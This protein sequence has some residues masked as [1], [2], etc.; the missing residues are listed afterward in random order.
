MR[1]PIENHSGASVLLDGLWDRKHYG[2]VPEHWAYVEAVLHGAVMLA[3]SFSIQSD[4]RFLKDIASQRLAMAK[5][6]K[7]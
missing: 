5:A 2:D 7:S 3:D 6:V 1:L 4:I